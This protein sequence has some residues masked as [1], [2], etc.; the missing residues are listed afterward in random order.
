MKAYQS[1]LCI[2]FYHGMQSEKARLP[3]PQLLSLENGS[4]TRLVNAY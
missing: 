3:L 2:L 4:G 1:A